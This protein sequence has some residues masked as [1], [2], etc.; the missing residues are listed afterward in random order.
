MGVGKV[1]DFT[2]KGLLDFGTCTEC[3]RC[4]SQCPAW[5]T[6]KPLSPKLLI[7]TPARPRAGQGA[8][9][10]PPP[11]RPRRPRRG[12]AA[13]ASCRSSG[14]GYAAD[15]P[16]V[17]VRRRRPGCGHRPRRAVVV[18]HLRRLR[19]AVPG[20]HRAR[21]PHRRHAPLPGADGVGLPRGGRHHAAQPRARRRPVGPGRGAAPG[22]GRAARLRGAGARGRRRARRSPTTSSTCSG[23]AAPARSTTGAQ[24]TARAVAT[25]LHEAGV[26]FMVLGDAETCTGDPARRMGHEFLFQMLA[27]QNVEV[28]NEAG[29]QAHRRHLRALLQH[30]A[31]RVPAARR[32]L[33]GGPPHDAARPAG[34]RRPARPG[35]PGRHSRSPTTTPATSAGTTGSSPPRARCSAAVPGAHAHRDAAQPG[36][37]VLLRR[38]RGADVDGRGPRHPDQPQPHRRGARARARPRHRRLPVLRRPC[39]PTA[40]RQRQLEGSRARVRRGARHRRGA[41]ALGPPRPR[42]RRAPDAATTPT[43]DSEDHHDRHRHDSPSRRPLRRRRARP[44]AP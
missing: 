18:H 43:S 42:R 5:N 21:R 11:R 34:R 9:G 29:R 1:E 14:T 25:L 8:V 10:S 12:A 4:Q 44:A 19:R 13:L 40:S 7:M 3:G 23:S 30:P 36:A 26:E 27:Q 17:G 33:R 28:L 35:G 31:Q 6:D 41:A 2:W 37:V 22:V 38:R 15:A 39:S 16:L 20:R 32:P 24:R